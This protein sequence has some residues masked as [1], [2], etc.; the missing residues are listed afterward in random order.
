MAFSIVGNEV[1]NI[2][3]LAI[4]GSYD[5]DETVSSLVETSMAYDSFQN[6]FCTRNPY[7]FTRTAYNKIVKIY[8]FITDAK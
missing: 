2:V 3:F 1:W 8:I 4:V 6:Y 5:L 7:N